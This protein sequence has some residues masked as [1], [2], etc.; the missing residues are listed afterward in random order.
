MFFKVFHKNRNTIGQLMIA[1]M[2]VGTLGFLLS[3]DGSISESEAA[4]CCSTGCSA[5]VNLL[6]LGVNLAPICPPP[7][8]YAKALPPAEVIFFE[9][10]M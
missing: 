10:G 4:S 2:F 3:Y 5:C 9:L 7:F 6:S 1:L 8:V